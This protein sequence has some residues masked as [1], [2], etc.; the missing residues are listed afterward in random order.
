M[1]IDAMFKTTMYNLALFQLMVPTAVGYI[2]VAHFFCES[3]NSED[4]ALALVIIK[5]WMSA[6]R[7]HWKC[8]DFMSDKSAAISNALEKVFPGFYGHHKTV[9]REFP[10]SQLALVHFLSLYFQKAG[11]FCA[12]STG[13]KPG[14]ILHRKPPT[15]SGTCV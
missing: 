15:M 8:T 2:T 5:E 6:D 12:A 10:F 11:N 7:L 14:L 9:I 3:E 1:F 4:V 13:K